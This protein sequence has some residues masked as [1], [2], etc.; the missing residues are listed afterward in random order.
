MQGKKQKYG[1]IRGFINYLRGKELKPT[2]GE[3][4]DLWIKICEE[5]DWSSRQKHKKYFLFYAG[6]GVAASV[7]LAIFWFKGISFNQ[8]K[9]M[10]ISDASSTLFAHSIEETEDVQLIMSTDQ[11]IPLKSNATIEYSGNGQ[12]AINSKGKS[13][14]IED[15]NAMEE[16]NQVIVPKGKHT[17]LLLSDGSCLHINSG[18]KV[19][20]PRIFNG[21]RREIFVNGEIYIDVKHDEKAP[22]YV[23]T[24]DFE[25]CVLG[26]AFNVHAYSSDEYAEVVLLRGRV[27][28]KDQQEHDLQL[29]PNQ[30][31]LIQDKKLAGKKDV[32]ASD[33][34]SW[35]QGLLILKGEPLDRVLSK[36]ERYYGVS[37]QYDSDVAKLDMHGNLDMNYDLAE[38][39]H[40]IAITAPIQ[41]K[42]LESGYYIQIAR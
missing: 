19:I 3:M 24:S 31:A 23:K 1:V 38:V 22:F 5:V 13:K 2:D 34:I 21:K 28:I 39:L 17:R 7:L 32:E 16:Y 14:P 9:K 40:R 4:N 42:K 10:D 26:T 29:L 41:I 15:V 35:I 36:L 11:I 20:Y 30:L 33:Y 37:I 25:V 12:V 27:Q 8:E 18:T 6:W